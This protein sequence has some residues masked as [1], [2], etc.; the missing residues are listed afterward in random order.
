MTHERVQTV[1]T[2]PTH[3]FCPVSCILAQGCQL[4][5]DSRR[6]HAHANVALVK[7]V[8]SL[9]AAP[10]LQLEVLLE[11]GCL[12]GCCHSQLALH[13]VMLSTSTLHPVSLS[14]VC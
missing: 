4:C 5:K 8:A 14:T 13:Q 2:N 6:C 9:N 3:P 11:P 1:H 12:E 10:L 7:I